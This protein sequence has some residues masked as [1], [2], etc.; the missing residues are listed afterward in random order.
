MG[1]VEGHGVEDVGCNTRSQILEGS[2]SQNFQAQEV[3]T[4]L[5]MIERPKECVGTWVE[6]AY[7]GH[8]RK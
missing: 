2:G 4:L 7:I 1:A 6:S 8:T 5:K 3:M